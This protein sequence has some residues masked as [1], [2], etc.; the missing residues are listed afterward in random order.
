MVANPS[1]F[2]VMFL[3]LK[4][5]QNLAMEIN[6][7]VIANSKKV[8]LLGV[9]IDSQLNFKN[10][11]KTVCVKANR[12]VSAFARV[13]NY[14]DFQKAKLLHESFV[15]STFKYCPL[16]WMFCGE[17]ANDSIDRV[18]KWALRILH[19]DHESMSEALLAKN[20]EINIHTQNLRALM[21]E[22]YKHI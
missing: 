19:D 15:A 5:N 20:D 8:K 13:A 12:K 4:K 21:T 10:H 11:A 9:T 22:I 1:K 17:I 6:G 18:R 14:I 16:N 7:D 2:Q 3:G